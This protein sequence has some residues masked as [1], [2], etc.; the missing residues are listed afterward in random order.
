MI[1]HFEEGRCVVTREPGD[2]IFYG[3]K[4]A[5]GE[6]RLLYHVKK[7]LQE[8]GHDVIKKRMWRDGH[9]V[10]DIQQYIRTR[11]GVEPSFMI[12]NAKWALRGADVDWRER[13]WV[14]LA[15][16]RHIW[17]ESKSDD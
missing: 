4:N 1:I 2:P 3:V 11:N 14:E 17:K 15:M 13:G 5:A 16:L 6:S 10:D 9:L 12:W 8:M 7:K